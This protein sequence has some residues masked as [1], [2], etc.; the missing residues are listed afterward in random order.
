M[1]RCGAG[2]SWIG[3]QYDGDLGN[4]SLGGTNPGIGMATQ[5][6][7]S[8]PDG[9]A[10]TYLTGAIHLSQASDT[11]YTFPTCAIRSDHT[12]WCWGSSAAQS[13]GPGLFAGTTG[14]TAGLPVAT[15]M[16]ASASDA[17]PPPTILA[18]RI[19]VGYRHACVLSAGKVS[20]WG[21]NV[22]GNLGI[23]NVDLSFQPYPVSVMTGNG[24]PTTVDEVVSGFDFSCARAGGGV[25]CWG[26]NSAQEIGNPGVA[27]SICNS[28]YCVPVP[29]PVQQS[30]DDG[31][32]TSVPDAGAG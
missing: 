26:T 25:W 5:V 18:N 21:E 16:A 2:P 3:R 29:T 14:S 15:P 10:P 1:A 9:G 24:L 12:L 6:V 32:V 7:T 20:C 30:T 22:A 13:G 23:G 17:G 8:A 19:S 27:P 4:G 11:E 28:N 31:G